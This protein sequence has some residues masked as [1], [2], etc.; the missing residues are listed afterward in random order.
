MLRRL[1]AVPLILIALLLIAMYSTQV[2]YAGFRQPVYVDIPRGTGSRGIAA[3]LER[4]G[5][6]RYRWQFLLAR[7]L[8]PRV[9]LQAGEYLFEQP[10]SPWRVLERLAY[11]DVFYHELVVHEG[12]NTFDIAAA[13]EAQGI[14]PAAAFLEA[15]RDASLVRDLDPGAP[16]LEGYLF[17]DTY[18]VTRRTTPARLCRMMTGRFRR[19]WRELGSPKAGIHDT[20]TLAS[21]VEEEAKLPQERPLIAS[22]FLNR[23]RAGVALQCDPTAIYAAL[24]EA[25]YRGAIHRSDLDRRQAYNT[26]QYP[27][28]PPGPIANPGLAS[29]RAALHPAQTDYLYFVLRA[30][31]SASHQFSSN[32]AEHTRAV[33]EYRRELHNQA[34]QAHGAA[35]VR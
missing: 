21:L 15:S 4:N 14:L 34:Q 22:V 20:V 33:Q 11:G 28:L 29:L 10:A 35:R 30:D 19:A 1:A 12:D 17:P 18:W 24:L 26:Y 16:S 6:I 32:L 7:V 3:L 25:R 2:P 27:G 23:L 8:R 5:V 13:L 9:T 31:G